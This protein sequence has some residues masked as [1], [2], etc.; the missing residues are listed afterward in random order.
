MGCA[1]AS[2][3]NRSPA[4]RFQKGNK[5]R[6]AKLVLSPLEREYINIYKESPEITLE[7]YGSVVLQERMDKVYRDSREAFIQKLQRECPF[8]T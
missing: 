6:K 8:L 4:A 2:V 1:V 5:M 7:K 3:T